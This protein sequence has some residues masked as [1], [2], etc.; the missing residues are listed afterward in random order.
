[1]AKVA[2]SVSMDAEFAASLKAEAEKRGEKFSPL[3]CRYIEA[4]RNLG[5]SLMA[6]T[7]RP[8]YDLDVDSASADEQ[9]SIA[10]PRERVYNCISN[11]PQTL[12]EIAEAS[13]VPESEVGDIIDELAN[14]GEPIS[15]KV[16]D[17]AWRCWEGS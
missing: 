1:M 16:I 17:G 10:I 8:D 11:E 6:R 7:D 3:V 4:G 13:G 12:A 2:I 14:A 15:L 9:A 5:G